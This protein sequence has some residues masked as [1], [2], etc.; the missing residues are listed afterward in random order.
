MLQE[1]K[2]KYR[3]VIHLIIKHFFDNKFEFQFYNNNKR[4]LLRNYTLNFKYNFK[5]LKTKKKK[6]KFQWNNFIKQFCS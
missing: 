4:G 6:K 2:L 3:I 1:I 5:S